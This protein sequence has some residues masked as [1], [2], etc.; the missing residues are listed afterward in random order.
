MGG[1]NW[2]SSANGACIHLE[3]TKTNSGY[4]AYILQAYSRG[5]LRYQGKCVEENPADILQP[6]AC[7]SC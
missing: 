2:L 4:G 3:D 7:D 6:S 5:Y 1:E